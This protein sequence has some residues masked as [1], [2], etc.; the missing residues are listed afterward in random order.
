[1]DKKYGSSRFVLME[2]LQIKKSMRR[3]TGTKGIFFACNQMFE[4]SIKLQ[5]SNSLDC[6]IHRFK[7]TLK[8]PYKTTSLNHT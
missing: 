2:A 6:P 1:M 4:I 8:Q 3:T 5:K 7:T